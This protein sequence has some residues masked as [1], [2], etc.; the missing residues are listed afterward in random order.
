MAKVVRN[1][2]LRPHV[3][4]NMSGQEVVLA[5]DQ[6]F[7]NGVRIG[8]IGHQPGDMIALIRPVDHGT[9]ELIEKKVAEKFPHRRQGVAMA[10]PISDVV[11]DE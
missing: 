2:E 10:T 3:G 11:D 8:Y 6:I 4:R 7:L 1:I 5:Q 9:R